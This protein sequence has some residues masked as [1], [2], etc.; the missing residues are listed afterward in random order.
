MC[1]AVAWFVPYGS[2][3]VMGAALESLIP[4]AAGHE[5]IRRQVCDLTLIGVLRLIT[6]PRRSWLPPLRARSGTVK[7]FHP[8]LRPAGI[9]AAVNSAQQY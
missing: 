2:S 9:L 6:H 4:F 5:I 7:S 8:A 1:D 3:V